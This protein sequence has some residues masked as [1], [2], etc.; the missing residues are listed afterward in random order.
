MKKPT[1]L[2][3]VVLAVTVALIGGIISVVPAVAQDSDSQSS[4]I[5]D[6]DTN[7]QS[8]DVTI[9]QNAEIGDPIPDIGALR[10]P[11]DRRIDQ[12]AE[13]TIENTLE[14]NDQISNEQTFRKVPTERPGAVE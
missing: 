14:D 11:D 8:N 9:N 10:P 6:S 13:V 4:T 5:D 7:T 1:I 12:N 2:M 3:A